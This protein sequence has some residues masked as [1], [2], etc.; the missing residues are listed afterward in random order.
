M[1]AQ[2]IRAWLCDVYPGIRWQFKYIVGYYVQHLFRVVF[3]HN[4]D[5]L[6]WQPAIRG[7][8]CPFASTFIFCSERVGSSLDGDL[9]YMVPLQYIPTNQ[10]GERVSTSGRVSRWVNPISA[11]AIGSCQIRRIPTKTYLHHNNHFVQK[12]QR[13]HTDTRKW[14]P[15]SILYVYISIYYHTPPVGGQAARYRSCTQYFSFTLHITPALETTLPELD[16]GQIQYIT[17]DCMVSVLTP[18]SHTVARTNHTVLSNFHVCSTKAPTWD[19]FFLFYIYKPFHDLQ[20]GW[21]TPRSGQNNWI[22]STK[23]RDSYRHII[24]TNYVQPIHIENRLMSQ[25]VRHPLPCRLRRDCCAVCHP[26]PTTRVCMNM[27]FY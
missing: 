25:P 24:S 7:G 23:Q 26:I 4:T 22:S 14:G 16:D 6:A 17:P 3:S 21:H 20:Y 10:Q 15:A 13:L 5:S 11:S 19:H 8:T 1:W 12:S 18:P 2:G 27:R 9:Y